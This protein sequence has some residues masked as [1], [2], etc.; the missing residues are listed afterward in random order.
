MGITENVQAGCH[1]Q[2]HIKKNRA[3]IV[4]G[5]ENWSDQNEIKRRKL[6][7][8]LYKLKIYR[9]NFIKWVKSFKCFQETGRT[10]KK[11]ISYMKEQK[12][13]V[14]EWLKIIGNKW[15]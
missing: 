10:V 5:S 1:F 7:H 8:S 11:G 2:N 6:K 4:S 14:S 13:E 3:K 12:K 15:K 9:H